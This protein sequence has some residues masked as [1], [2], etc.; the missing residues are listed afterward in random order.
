MPVYSVRDMNTIAP[1]FEGWNE[2]MIWSCLS[3]TIGVAY[4]ERLDAP[5]SAQVS[6]GDFCAFAGKANDALARNKPEN[7]RS[8]Y[9]ILVPQHQEWARTIERAWG[10]AVTP[11][12]RYATK[13]DDSFDR[14]KLREFAASLPPR[15]EL[16]PIGRELYEA[17]LALEWARDLCVNYA[18]YE[19]YE[20][21]GMGVAV[22]KDGVVVAGASSYTSYPGGI[23]IEIDTREDERR[24][25]LATACGAL[26]ILNCLE[27]GA[28]PSWD[29]HNLES[30]ALAQKLGYS[31]DREYP[32]YEI[33]YP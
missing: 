22:L 5:E 2:T 25:G 23:E 4:A 9:A 14:A 21:I 32:A 10:A 18:S 26:L 20:A 30:L 15:Y 11:H 24:K 19:Q 8:N 13:K 17:I 7:L 6:V 29:A 12:T 31:F 33:E 1:L 16:R 27:R 28:Y 3:G